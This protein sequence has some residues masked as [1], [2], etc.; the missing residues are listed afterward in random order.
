VSQKNNLRYQRHRASSG[1]LSLLKLKLVDAVRAKKSPAPAI[2][3]AKVLQRL[4][5]NNVG[6]VYTRSFFYILLR[7]ASA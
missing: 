4:L 7:L 3:L 2:F 6:R 5:S 1:R